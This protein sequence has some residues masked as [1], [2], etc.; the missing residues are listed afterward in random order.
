VARQAEFCRG[1]VGRLGFD[2]DAGRLDVSAHPFCEGVGPG[3]TRLTTHYAEDQFASAISST[4]HET[5]H[6]LYEQNLPKAARFGEP[7]AE[8]A[9]MAI[10]ESQ[11]RLWEN[12]VGRS[13]PFW[14]W[15]LPELRAAFAA[16]ELAALDVET[17]YRGMNEV[18]PNLIRIESDEATY[19][20]HIMLRFDL[21]RAMLSGELAVA[22]L[23]AAWNERMRDDL[24][25]QVPDDARGCLQDIHWSMGAFGYFP[26][27]TLGNLYAAQLWTT[28]R[29]ALPGLDDDLRRGE[30]GGLLAWLKENVHAHGRRYTAAELCERITGRRL[31]HE[32]LLAYLRAKIEPIY[33]L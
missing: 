10:H 6:G 32:P 1:L 19:N 5:G 3:D 13:R 4:L 21:E 22:D 30:F 8:A 15:A 23:P 25:L 26:T 12:L 31:D 2:L 27:Y 24:G 20:L 28:I 9:G 14:E 17:A 11:S 7:L 29:A 16:P 18:R 33:G